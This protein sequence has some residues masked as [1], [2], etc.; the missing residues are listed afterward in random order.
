MKI[1]TKKNTKKSTVT[2]KVKKAIDKKKKE[3]K[4]KKLKADLKKTFEKGVKTAKLSSAKTLDTLN[5]VGITAKDHAKVASKEL[6]KVSK[7]AQTNAKKIIEIGKLKAQNVIIK[8]NINKSFEKVGMIVYK[9]NINVDNIEIQQLINE[10][11]EL[12]QQLK[13]ISEVKVGK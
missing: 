1:L 7:T 6:S 12:K 10:I 3:I 8:N 9:E 2:D 11:T 4:T 13:Q 5:K